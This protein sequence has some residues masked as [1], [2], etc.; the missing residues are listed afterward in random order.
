MERVERIFPLSISLNIY[1]EDS[2]GYRLF[3][4]L[5]YRSWKFETK[6]VRFVHVSRVEKLPVG[7]TIQATNSSA[8]NGNR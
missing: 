8:V 6:E 4:R 5:L 1:R 3:P 2:R 7:E